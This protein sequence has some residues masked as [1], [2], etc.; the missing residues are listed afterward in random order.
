MVP[1]DTKGELSSPENAKLARIPAQVR[2]GGVA[3]WM[4]ARPDE[5]CREERDS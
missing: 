1:Y 5:P 4:E 3:V 2:T